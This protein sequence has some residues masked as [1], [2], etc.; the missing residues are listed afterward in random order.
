MLLIWFLIFFISSSK[1]TSSKSSKKILLSRCSARL[2]LE[3]DKRLILSINIWKRIIS[4]ANIRQEMHL[5]YLGQFRS[6]CT[7][8]NNTI[9]LFG[10]DVS[11]IWGNIDR[12]LSRWV[13]G[14][15]SFESQNFYQEFL[16]CS[17]WRGIW[18]NILMICQS[19]KVMELW[20]SCR[21]HHLFS[22]KQIFLY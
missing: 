17:K 6:K 13:E 19:Q 20:L 16:F 5:V 18:T 1:N 9:W 12:I 10:R 2:L 14:V 21:Q 8:P 22:S 4:T 11:V 3:V 15:H 7:I